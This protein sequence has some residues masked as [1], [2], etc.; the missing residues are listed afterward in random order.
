MALLF[1]N[2]PLSARRSRL[3][4]VGKVGRASQSRTVSLN[5]SNGRFV[6]IMR[7]R[8]RMLNGYQCAG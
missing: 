5:R 6:V 2:N 3:P 7:S 4:D 8:P 1:L